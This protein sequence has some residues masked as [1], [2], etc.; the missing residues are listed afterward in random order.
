MTARRRSSRSPRARPASPPPGAAVEVAR[1]RRA[2]ARRGR[3]TTRQLGILR[4]APRTVVADDGVPLHVEVDELETPSDAKPQAAEAEEPAADA[5]VRA[6]LRAEP[7][8][9]A[10]PARG[11]TAAWSAPCSTTSVRTAGPAGP[12]PSTPPSTSSATTCCGC[13]TP[14]RRTGRWCCRALD[15]RHDDHGAAEQ[16]P[17]L[18]GDRIVGVGADLHD[19]RGPRPAAGSSCRCSPKALGWPGGH[20]GPSP[21]S[22]AAPGGRRRAPTRAGRRDGR[23]RPVRVRRRGAGRLRRLRG[24]DAVRHPVRGARRVLPELRATSTSTTSCRRSARVPTTMICGTADRLTPIGTA[25]SC[26]NRSPG[27]PCS[28]SRAP[29]TW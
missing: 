15:G 26:T 29:A 3:A 25:A 23:D 24:R 9:L 1:E 16:H 19:R 13:S 5:R 7:R 12:T 18:F 20:R 14:S 8:L 21:A 6:R 28:S 10:L 27:Q 11:A 22:P 4:S 17:E 2:I